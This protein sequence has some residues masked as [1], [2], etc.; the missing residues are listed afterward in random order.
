MDDISSDPLVSPA[1]S[2]SPIHQFYQIEE[3]KKAA[4]KVSKFYHSALHLEFNLRSWETNNGW[5]APARF[6]RSYDSNPDDID[7]DENL[8]DSRHD[9]LSDIDWTNLNEEDLQERLLKIER[10][11]IQRRLRQVDESDF[12]VLNAFEDLMM[13]DDEW[14]AP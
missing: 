13:N 12:K 1:L 9:P 10:Q 8:E 5:D 7:P 6:I 3:R 14:S 2:D 11:T 4:E